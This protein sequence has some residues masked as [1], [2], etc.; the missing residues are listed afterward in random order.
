[1]FAF[2]VLLPVAQIFSLHCFLV[3][4]GPVDPSLV[5]LIDR[6]RTENYFLHTASDI[7]P[8]SVTTQDFTSF[9]G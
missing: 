3:V 4:L 6:T 8:S 1:M 9:F 5:H 7:R 2:V